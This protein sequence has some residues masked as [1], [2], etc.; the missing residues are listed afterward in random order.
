VPRPEQPIA[1]QW[2]DG[3]YVADLI[4]D[5]KEIDA[6]QAAG[7]LGVPIKQKDAKKGGPSLEKLIK[8]GMVEYFDQPAG[9]FSRGRI[10][11]RLESMDM[12]HCVG[13]A[14]MGYMD[15]VRDGE[16][17]IMS[18]RRPSGK[19]LFTIEAE[20]QLGGSGVIE[21]FEQ[22]KG[23]GN[24]V[25]GF[26]R[27]MQRAIYQ[28]KAEA[29]PV[30]KAFKRD[31]V[32]RVIE[33]LDSKPNHWAGRYLDIVDFQPAL[34][35]I[36]DLVK[37]GDP[38]AVGLLK[39][40][41]TLLGAEP[42]KWVVISEAGA[43]Q[44][45]ADD[46]EHAREQHIAAFPGEEIW[47]I[48]PKSLASPA[49]LGPA[50]NQVRVF[51]W[52]IVATD[53][54]TQTV[55]APTEDAAYQIAAERFPEMNIAGIRRADQNPAASS[56]CGHGACEGF[57]L[58]YQRRAAR[59]PPRHR[60]K[61]EGTE[62]VLD[63]VR[64]AEPTHEFIEAPD[65][66]KWRPSDL[67]PVRNVT[68]LGSKGYLVAIP[69]EN[70]LF[71]EGNIWNFGHAAALLEGIRDGS[72]HVLQAPAGRVYRVMASDVKQTAKYERDGELSY[73]VG[74]TEPW[75]KAE[76]GQYHAQLLD[77][78]HRAAAAIL[79]GDPYIYVYVAENSRENVRKK[80]FE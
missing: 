78:N 29:E 77:G 37:E 45:T 70:I 12:G 38:W 50:P 36:A 13:D 66:S 51:T 75:T 65:Q 42:D 9:T 39:K 18:L 1:Y 79:A 64:D 43:R 56:S 47:S 60:F 54:A 30:I 25:P 71:M 33:F 23:K 35:V 73:Q 53:G 57:C 74:M 24:R 4:E 11:M 21:R 27:G 76:M 52:I 28:S 5:D 58:P 3:F 16:I 7:I 49:S 19:P 41:P 17:K 69:V 59:N 8:D 62:E 44:W 80:D 72:N 48:E 32:Q 67:H 61:F 22:I 6:V 15:G 46:A 63:S 14:N 2:A 10:A 31:E 68:W 20:L 55:L 34:F 26:D 40:Y